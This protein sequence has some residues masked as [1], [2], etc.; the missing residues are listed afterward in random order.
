MR[1]IMNYV[2]SN[3]L[4]LAQYTAHSLRDLNNIYVHT[5]ELYTTVLQ[6]NCT[7]QQMTICNS[8]N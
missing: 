3:L 5:P 2:L 6:T 8:L 1:H 7:V 4:Q